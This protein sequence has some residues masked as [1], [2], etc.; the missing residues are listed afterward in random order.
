MLGRFLRCPLLSYP[1]SLTLQIFLQFCL[2][3]STLNQYTRSGKSATMQLKLKY[4]V[5]GTRQRRCSVKKRRAVKKAIAKKTT[6]FFA[7]PKKT[8]ADFDSFFNSSCAYL[9]RITGL[10]VVSQTQS[11]DSYLFRCSY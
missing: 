4:I 8:P 6:D 2:N 5:H 1:L 10:A 11:Q 9:W 3:I 7:R